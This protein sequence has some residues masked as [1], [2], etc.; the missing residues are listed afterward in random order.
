[1]ARA[2]KYGDTL[3]IGQVLESAKCI[4]QMQHVICNT[5]TEAIFFD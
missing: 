2:K 1:M 5:Y 3:A 4:E